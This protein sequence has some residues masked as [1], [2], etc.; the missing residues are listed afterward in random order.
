[1]YALDQLSFTKGNK[2]WGYPF[3]LG[4]FEINHEDF[5]IIAQAMGAIQQEEEHGIGI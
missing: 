5:L 4:H 1:M 3:R 2:N